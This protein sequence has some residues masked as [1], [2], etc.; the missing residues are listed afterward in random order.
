MATRI[1]F[2]EYFGFTDEEVD[3]LYRQYLKKTCITRESLRKWYNGY[4]TATG[5][6]RSYNPRSV[7]CAL[8]DNQI[9]NYW[10]SSGKYDSIFTY[11]RY[12]IDEIQDNLT[13][14]FA[15]GN[16]VR[17]MQQLC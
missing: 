11:I 15:G 16:S 2:S 10:V 3:V 4:H 8:T 9:S 17:N 1:R 14:M 12:N 7:V 6:K 13:L 5:E